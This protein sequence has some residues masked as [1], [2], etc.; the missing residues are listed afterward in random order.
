MDYKDNKENILNELRELDSTYLTQLKNQQN[1]PDLLEGYLSEVYHKVIERKE[2]QIVTLIKRPQTWLI[3]ASL[4][5]LFA[6]FYLLH[7]VQTSDL[8]NLDDQEILAYLIES[9]IMTTE[10][11]NDLPGLSDQ[12]SYDIDINDDDIINY[13]DDDLENLDLIELNTY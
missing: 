9:D 2:S 10:D 13:L 7:S 3:A 6:R 11:L 4:V 5:I 8:M 12:L 1:K